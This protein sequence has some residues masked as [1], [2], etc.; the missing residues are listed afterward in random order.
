MLG[1]VGEHAAHERVEADDLSDMGYRP[2]GFADRVAEPVG[3][4]HSLARQEARILPASARTQRPAS[5]PKYR[6][7]SASEFALPWR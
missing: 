3:G 6:Q 2:V 5:L 7:A 1:V 4:I